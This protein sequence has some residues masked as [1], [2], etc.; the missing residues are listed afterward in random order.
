[1]RLL[2]LALLLAACNAAKICRVCTSTVC[3]KHGAALLA[4]SLRACAADDVEVKETACLRVCSK[5]A[6]VHAGKKRNMGSLEGEEA[7]IGAAAD[8]LT[9]ID[10]LD[11]AAHGALLERLGAGEAVLAEAT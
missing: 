3:K 11:D 6:V 9:A 1:M 5:G 8:V 10:A 4:A 2:L 7:A